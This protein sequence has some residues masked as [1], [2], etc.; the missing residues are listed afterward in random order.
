MKE[1][2]KEIGETGKETASALS[3]LMKSL[4]EKKPINITLDQVVQG[5]FFTFLGFQLLLIKLLRPSPWWLLIFTLYGLMF[6]LGY[7]F[8]FYYNKK[9]KAEACEVLGM[10]LGLKGLQHLLGALPSWLSYTEREKVAWLNSTLEEVWP[11]YDKGV[12]KMVKQQVEGI[13]EQTLK[14]MKVPGIKKVGFKQLTFGD[15][16][17]RVESI[18]VNEHQ[19][20]AMVM[21]VDVRWC[22]EANI[23]LAIE[24][25]AGAKMCPRITDISFV[26]SLRITLKPLVDIIPGFAAAMVTFR[27]PPR[28]KYNLDFGKALG[29]KYAASGIKPFINYVI[30]NV[31]VSMLVWPQRLVI[32]IINT[33]D[34]QVEIAKLQYRNQGMVKITVEEANSLRKTDMIG[35]SDPFVELCTDENHVV[36]TKVQKDTLTP[37]W[38]ETFWLL[39]QEPNSQEM[40][41]T[42]YDKDFFSAKELLSLNVGNAI[43]SKELLGRVSVRL[44]Q[45]T[46]QEPEPLT[47]WYHLGEGDWSAPEG[48]GKGAGRIKLTCLYRSLETFRSDE[49]AVAERGVLMVRIQQAEKLPRGVGANKRMSVYVRVK[50]GDQV[51]ITP[52]VTSDGNHQFASRNIFEFYDIKF[53]ANIKLKVIEKTAAV[54]DE[55]GD[56]DLGVSEVA[57]AHDVNPLTGKKEH[58]LLLRAFPLENTSGALVAVLR[59]APYF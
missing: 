8:L 11:F 13:F 51:A 14:T 21:E 42:V 38:G 53:N 36:A 32:P 35:S 19:K 33:E 40:R 49:L 31:M 24:L 30:R 48:C 9:R 55:I 17:F 47:K 22:G 37:K 2:I 7:S 39:V 41:V 25:S 4:K 27:K 43:G 6:G 54:D 23:T 3:G 58:G 26:G 57:S 20:D 12:C 18:H 28:L 16:P 34:M 59:F 29:G 10:N 56:V 50:C 46:K 52:T 5:L 44:N 45:I 1:A 15:A